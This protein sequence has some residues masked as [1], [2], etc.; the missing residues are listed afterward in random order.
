M[1]PLSTI[2]HLAVGFLVA[3]AYTGVA[4]AAPI[5]CQNPSINH[6]QIDD[7]QVLACLDAGNGNISGNP[8]GGNADPF[9]TG[10]GTDYVLLGKN[11]GG[12]NPFDVAATQNNSTGTWSFDAS[13]WDDYASVAI[14]FKFG[15]GNNPDSWFVYQVASDIASGN[16]SFINM[17]FNPAGKPIGGG[18][19]HVNLYGVL[20]DDEDP[21]QG[22]SEPGVLFL[23]GAGLL[24][25]A[26]IRRRHEAI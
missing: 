14:G 5:L 25:L 2:K 19:S 1:K 7:S 12:P 9:L 11:D 20:G 16:W 4:G 15:T 23:L 18:L 17:T 26:W 6:M 10:V 8:N 13:V 24:G 22:I 21:P 3:L